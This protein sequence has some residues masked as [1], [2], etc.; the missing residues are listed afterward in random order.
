MNYAAETDLGEAGEHRLYYEITAA[1]QNARREYHEA[2]A[3]GKEC[4]W[5]PT[6][7]EALDW[8][9]WNDINRETFAGRYPNKGIHPTVF[10]T[11]LLMGLIKEVGYL[12]VIKRFKNIEDVKL[13]WRE[14]LSAIKDVLLKGTM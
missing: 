9:F 14:R 11:M 3:T 5:N 4:R 10:S 2:L 12:E 1:G 8:S 7:I 6:F 13:T